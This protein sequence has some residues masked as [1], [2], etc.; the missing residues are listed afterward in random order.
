MK[1]YLWNT[2]L[3]LPAEF[4]AD[5]VN[6]TSTAQR[7]TRWVGAAKNRGWRHRA[8]AAATHQQ[9]SSMARPWDSCRFFHKLQLVLAPTGP[10]L[11]SFFFEVI[12]VSNC[13]CR[14][15][16]SYSATGNMVYIVHYIR[17]RVANKGRFCP[18]FFNSKLSPF[19][20]MNRVM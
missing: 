9:S 20:Q 11:S 18:F 10:T 1:C 7:I 16:D 13:T 6:K 4:D 3:K 5:A 8:P 15:R 17:N 14:G 2:P 19:V 12:Y